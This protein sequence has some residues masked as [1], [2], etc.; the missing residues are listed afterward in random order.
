MEKTAVCIDIA[1]I[2]KAAED[3]I[4]MQHRSWFCVCL[5]VGCNALNFK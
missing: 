1:G 4:L 3:L 2:L 5:V